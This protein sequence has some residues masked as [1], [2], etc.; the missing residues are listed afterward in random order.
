[1]LGYF[2]ANITTSGVSLCGLAMFYFKRILKGPTTQD[3]YGNSNIFTMQKYI[4]LIFSNPKKKNPL[5]E[6][7]KNLQDIYYYNSIL[8]KISNFNTSP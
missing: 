5:Q 8:N 4:Y 2:E 1:L 3:F 7:Q 6:S